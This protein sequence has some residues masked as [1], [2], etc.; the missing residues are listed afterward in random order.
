M[1]A[2]P[3][4][5]SNTELVYR[6]QEYLSRE[7]IADAERWGEIDAERWGGFFQWLN[8]SGLMESPLEP[9]EGFTNAYLP[10]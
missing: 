1:E 10:E 8:D 7:Y 4:L 6:S 3:E 2:A 5:K 9:T